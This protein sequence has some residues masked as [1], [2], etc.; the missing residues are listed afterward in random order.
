MVRVCYWHSY[1]HTDITH[2][3]TLY[4]HTHYSHVYA[5]THTHTHTH[6]H[7]QIDTDTHRQRQTHTHTHTYIHTHTH[8]YIHTHTHTW[9]GDNRR[10]TC[11]SNTQTDSH[12]IIVSRLKVT[13]IKMAASF[14]L[15]LNSM[16]CYGILIQQNHFKDQYM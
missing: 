4:A 12:N 14:R 11:L 2:A 15:P 8:T 16:R 1:I 7:P 10:V 13:L 9:R 6:P 3:R 5:H